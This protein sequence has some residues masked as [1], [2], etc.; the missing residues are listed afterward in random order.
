[1]FAA[2]RSLFVIAV[3]IWYIARE[4]H[5]SMF[6][7]PL[8]SWLLSEFD[9][10]RYVQLT[11]V[12]WLY[13][14]LTII[15]WLI[16]KSMSFGLQLIIM[17]SI[18]YHFI[19]TVQRFI[20]LT[21]TNY[22]LETM[23]PKSKCLEYTSIIVILIDVTCRTDVWAQRY[24]VC[25]IVFGII[26]HDDS[27]DISSWYMSCWIGIHAMVVPPFHSCIRVIGLVRCVIT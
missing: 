11:E 16:R 21:E 3:A 5:L 12:V 1:M 15:D 27:C 13:S 14:H 18:R 22:I 25:C 26:L 8:K 23:P 20:L 4:K 17:R 24:T 9:T 7:L 19:L 10:K 6:R 2:A